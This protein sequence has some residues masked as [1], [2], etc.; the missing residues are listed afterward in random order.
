[1]VLCSTDFESVSEPKVGKGVAWTR[2]QA[3][4]LVATAH[5]DSTC[6]ELKVKAVVPRQLLSDTSEEPPCSERCHARED[7]F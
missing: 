7:L 1:M 4:A 2:R 3:D 5:T 6:F